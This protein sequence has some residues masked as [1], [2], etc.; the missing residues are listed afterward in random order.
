MKNK[1]NKQAYFL[2][3]KLAT[4]NNVNIEDLKKEER[5]HVTCT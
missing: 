4:N 3:I 5:S 2:K 1:I